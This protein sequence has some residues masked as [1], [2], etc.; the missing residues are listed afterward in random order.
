MPGNIKEEEITNLMFASDYISEY[1]Y[2]KQVLLENQHETVQ[3]IISDLSSENLRQMIE[4]EMIINAIQ[5]CSDLG[6]FAISI[7]NKKI[8]EIIKMLSSLSETSIKEF[9]DK[10]G[11]ADIELLKNYMGYQEINIEQ[12][13]K[14]KYIRSCKRYQTD[15]L[16]ISTFYNKFYQL[17]LSY[18]HGLRL[19][20]TINADGQKLI[21]E[22]C[23]DNTLTIYNIPEMWWLESIEITEIIN[24]IFKKLYVPIIRKKVGEYLGIPFGQR[25]VQGSVKSTDPPDPKKTIPV[26]LSIISPWWCYQG[27]EPIPFY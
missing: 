2:Y 20:P 11:D 14:E 8:F 6:A 22:A 15:I 7:K 19:I 3:D 18:K 1:R 5:Y 26:K 9:Y 27:K 4:I 17:Y 13:D 25:R 10:I 16:K 23:K 24:N 12:S 21:F